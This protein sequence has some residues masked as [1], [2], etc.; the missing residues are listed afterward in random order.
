MSARRRHRIEEQGGKRR[1]G[2]HTAFGRGRRGTWGGVGEAHRA[3]ELAAARRFT[4][5]HF[6]CIYSSMRVPSSTRNC[7]SQAG[8]AGHAGAV[9]NGASVT[10]ASTGMSAYSPPASFT[11]GAQAG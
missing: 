3:H 1:D 10:A 6:N 2:A 4:S 11:S 5:P 9:T 7:A 8:C